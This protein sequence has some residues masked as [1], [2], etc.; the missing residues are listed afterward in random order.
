MR[1]VFRSLLLMG[2]FLVFP[3]LTLASEIQT[4]MTLKTDFRIWEINPSRLNLVCLAG[5]KAKVDIRDRKVDVTYVHL[6][7][8]SRDSI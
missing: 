3:T 4:S 7:G 8:Y 2:A 5:G 1:I 6:P